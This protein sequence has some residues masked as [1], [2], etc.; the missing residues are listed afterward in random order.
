MLTSSAQRRRILGFGSAFVILAVS[1]T[2]APGAGS[3]PLPKSAKQLNTAAIIKLYQGKTF[4]FQSVTSFGL[5]A[6]EVSYDFATNTNHVT[7]RLGSRQGSFSGKIRVHADKF[8]YA[9]DRAAERCNAVYVDGGYI[10]EVREGG[11]VDSVKQVLATPP[12]S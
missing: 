2:S 8:C 7:Y 12:H 4:A 10:Y 5:V 6:G 9:A 11:L 1:A 3:P